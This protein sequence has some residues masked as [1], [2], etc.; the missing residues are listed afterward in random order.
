MVEI[1]GLIVDAGWGLG[2][3]L[4]TEVREGERD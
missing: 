1:S 4:I 2:R 3:N